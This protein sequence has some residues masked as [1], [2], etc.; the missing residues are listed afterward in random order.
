MLT[1]FHAPTRNDLYKVIKAMYQADQFS[2]TKRK[3]AL[4]FMSRLHHHGIYGN[5][6]R[7]DL[8]QFDELTDVE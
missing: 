3:A 2:E 7:E 5:A 4:A 6:T 8:D 1:P